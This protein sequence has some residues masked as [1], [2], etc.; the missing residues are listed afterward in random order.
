[1]FALPFRRS[2]EMHDRIDDRYAER[3]ERE[4]WNDLFCV[5][6][7]ESTAVVR[8]SL[9]ALL[10]RAFLE[11]AL[12]VKALG[13]AVRASEL[14]ID[15]DGAARPFSAGRLGG[16]RD[17][18]VHDRFNGFRFVGREENPAAGDGGFWRVGGPGLQG[19]PQVFTARMP[20]LVLGSRARGV[21]G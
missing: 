21:W 1:M 2:E 15:I 13:I 5:E 7:G 18:A 9:R 17:D 16:R 19:A 8:Y 11:R 6:Q 3:H 20:L 12:G 14:I 10:R 4:C